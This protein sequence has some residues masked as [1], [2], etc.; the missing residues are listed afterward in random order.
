M[1]LRYLAAFGPA[2][3]QDIQAWC[4]LT[5]LGPAV[6]RLR[7]RLRVFH[8][9][10]GT[11][12]FDLPGAPR[13]DADVPAPARLL[14]EYDNLLLSHADRSRIIAEGYL[15]RVFTR[16]SFLIDGFVRGAWKIVAAGTIRTPGARAGVS[17]RRGSP[18]AGAR[19]GAST[20]LIE[21]F[22]RI[23]RTD[24]AELIEEGE[25]LLAFAAPGSPGGIRFE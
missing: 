15:Q 7:P 11:E 2:S 12:L 1:I 23:S 16:G 24:R 3:V 19:R 25:R 18:H 17:A 8:A 9:A 22:E 14:P 6:Q 21:P 5:R 13:P 10:D 4:W 20:L